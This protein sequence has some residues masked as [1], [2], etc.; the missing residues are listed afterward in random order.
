[1]ILIDLTDS[2]IF[3]PLLVQSVLVDISTTSQLV[4]A[5]KLNQSLEQ[6]P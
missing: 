6:E 1:M 5:V 4:I 2:V 3:A